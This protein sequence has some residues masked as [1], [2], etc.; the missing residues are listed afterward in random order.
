VAPSSEECEIAGLCKDA[1][2]ITYGMKCGDKALSLSRCKPQV[3]GD[4][5][6]FII[7]IKTQNKTST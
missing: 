3:S 5:H 1:Q 7:A 6:D 4:A 2:G